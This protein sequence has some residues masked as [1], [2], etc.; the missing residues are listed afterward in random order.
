MKNLF[1]AILVVGL[2]AFSYNSFADGT[3]QYM[4][5]EFHTGYKEYHIITADGGYENIKMESK[6]LQEVLKKL[7]ELAKDGWKV[8]QMTMT[9]EG[10]VRYSYLL[11]RE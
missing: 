7:N 4:M 11:E 6:G 1:T 9:E 8:S 3:K 5:L 10:A 2:L